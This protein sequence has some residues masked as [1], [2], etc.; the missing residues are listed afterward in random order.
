[1]KLLNMAES[2]DPIDQQNVRQLQNQLGFTL[3]D[4]YCDFLLRYNGGRPSE[5]AEVFR[6]NEQEGESTV[7]FFYSVKNKRYH[8][9]ELMHRNTEYSGRIPQGFLPIAKDSFGNQI[10]LGITG[11][12]WNQVC[13]WDHEQ[14]PPDQAAKTDIQII[15]MASTFEAF[16]DGLHSSSP[17]TD[18]TK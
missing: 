10:L 2:G 4:G 3:P 12:V 15:K 18:E 1:M 17:V 8:T 5:D 6:I 16:I 9:L 7:G 13:F 11:A 14:E